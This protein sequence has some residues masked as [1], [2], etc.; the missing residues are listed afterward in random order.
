[1]ERYDSLPPISRDDEPENTPAK[2]SKLPK[3]A[4]LASFLVAFATGVL[5]L[6]VYFRL[7]NG[8]LSGLAAYALFLT[9][10]VNATRV[11]YAIIRNQTP[12]T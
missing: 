12:T 10:L 2:P 1:M 5:L 9:I 6:L 7:R 4:G 3:L 11:L 8:E